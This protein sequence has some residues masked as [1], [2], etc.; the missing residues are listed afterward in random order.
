M[1]AYIYEYAFPRT[2]RLYIYIYIHIYN[3]LLNFCT[4]TYL[5]TSWLL[6]ADTG[7]APCPGRAKTGHAGK[8]II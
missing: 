2:I 4:R 1:Y 7:L 6:E 8:F 5:W 3:I